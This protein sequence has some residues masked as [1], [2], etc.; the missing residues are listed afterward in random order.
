MFSKFAKKITNFFMKNETLSLVLMVSSIICIPI[1]ILF[2]LN[3]LK[4]ETF[5]PSAHRELL[6]FS[7]PG[8]GHCDKFKPT[9]DLLMKNY[10][11]IKNI[12]LIQVV[13][14]EKPELVELFEIQG[15]PTILYAKD[16]KKISEYQGDRSYDDLV[17]YMKYSM[18][19]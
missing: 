12:K 3:S 8:C 4:N 17:K 1:I 13:S 2:L 19:T 7:M 11:S 14:N 15:F 9:W 6:F 18:T 5:S 16:N 10:G